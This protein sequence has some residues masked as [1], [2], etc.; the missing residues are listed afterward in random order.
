[1]R[2]VLAMFFALMLLSSTALALELP[3]EEDTILSVLD[4]TDAQRELA[5]LL[6]EPIFRHETRIQ[7]PEGTLYADVPM[8]M[9][10]LMQDHPELFHLGRNYGLGYYRNKPEY[11]MFVEPQYRMSAQEA[12]D[13][14]AMLYAQ[15]HMLV[16]AYPDAESLHDV[17]CS[18][19]VYGGTTEMMHTAPGALLEGV[20]LCE[21][22]AQALSLLYRMAGIPCGVIA[23]DAVNNQGKQERHA[24]NIAQLNGYTLIDPTWDDQN[25]GGY[26]THWFYGLSTAQMGVD[27][28]PDAN[29]RV[30]YCGMGNN[31]HENT[32]NLIYSQEDADAAIRRV[33]NGEVLDLRVPPK[34]LYASL[35]KN[36]N[37]FLSSYNQRNPEAMFYGTYSVTFCDSQQCF[38]IHKV[39]E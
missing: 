33:V 3:Y 21:G 9:Q 38:I 1:M 30:P 32:G 8:A 23:G 19:A 25:A 39:G 10:H 24:W 22:Y 28:M 27:H 29:Q 2:K 17:L 15:A 26:I 36:T 31:W 6:Y 20:A 13:L 5:E 14:R 35:V 16:R 7:L 11:A 4:M 12:A 34:A 18:M 37:D